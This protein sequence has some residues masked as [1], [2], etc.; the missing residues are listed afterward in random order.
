VLRNP[1]AAAR[2]Q[3]Y[4]VVLRGSAARFG[5]ALHTPEFTYLEWPDGSQQLFD[6]VKDPRE[7]VNL[8]ASPAHAATLKSLQERLGRRREE[9]ARSTA[10]P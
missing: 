3:A 6:A 1:A 8:A 4:T 7:Y 10:R 9:V 5:R 2:D